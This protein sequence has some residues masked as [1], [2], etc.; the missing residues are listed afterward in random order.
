LDLYIVI[1]VHVVATGVAV[2]IQIGIRLIPSLSLLCF[3]SVIT[4]LPSKRSFHVPTFLGVIT[5]SS[6]S[7][8]EAAGNWSRW[9]PE[10]PSF[11]FLAL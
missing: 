11:R 10:L 8:Q 1:G 6:T 7:A 5:G 4:T 2:V 9:K 3:M